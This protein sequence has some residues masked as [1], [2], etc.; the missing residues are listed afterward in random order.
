MKY[1]A[2]PK[3]LAA[4]GGDVTVLQKPKLRHSDGTECWGLWDEASRTI[5]LD[6]TAEPR[7]RWKVL[8]HEWAHVALDDSGLSNG[9]PDAMVESLCDAFAVARMRERFG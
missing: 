7:H 3:R 8:F 4:P 9:L 2:I 5:T 1:P 6:P